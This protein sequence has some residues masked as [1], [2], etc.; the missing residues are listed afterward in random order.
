MHVDRINSASLHNFQIFYPARVPKG[1]KYDLHSIMHYSPLVSNTLRLSRP[2]LSNEYYT[3]LHTPLLFIIQSFS[4]NPF[5]KMPTMTAMNAKKDVLMGQRDAL[6]FYD[7]KA[8]N[9]E[10]CQGSCK[11][12]CLNEGYIL[13]KN[14]RCVCVCPEGLTGSRC[15]R[16]QTPCGGKVD[17]A[18][19]QQKT[20]QT[21]TSYQNKKCA[22][23]IT[24]PDGYLVEISFTRFDISKVQGSE[25]KCAHIVEVR[26]NILGQRGDV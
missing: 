9:V 7:V 20:I 13:N 21:P 23:L 5:I 17:L 14:G 18:A 24:A 10:Y 8:I 19:N 1:V 22:W 25:K 6:S 3:V 2:L 11:D 15:E 12:N 4:V 26:N 16:V